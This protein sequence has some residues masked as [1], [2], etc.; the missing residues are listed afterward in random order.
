MSNLLLTLVFFLETV[1]ITKHFKWISFGAWYN[2]LWHYSV[3]HVG[4]LVSLSIFEF[5]HRTSKIL[6]VLTISL[7]NHVTE[8]IPR[9]F[10]VLSMCDLSCTADLKYFIC[11]ILTT[12]FVFI[13]KRSVTK[14]LTYFK[15]ISFREIINIEFF[16][17]IS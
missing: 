16:F 7:F 11:R 8:F 4:L 3:Y 1:K 14:T 12:T 13:I 5:A 15:H 17:I 10:S 9:M 2:L 6:F